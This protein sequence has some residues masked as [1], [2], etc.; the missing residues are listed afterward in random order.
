MQPAVLLA[1]GAG[2][3]L[4]S[5]GDKPKVDDAPPSDADGYDTAGYEG[6]GP[7]DGGMPF[8]PSPPPSGSSGAPPSG[9]G[10]ASGASPSGSGGA[11]GAPPSGSSSSSNPFRSAPEAG[12]ARAPRPNL[13]PPAAVRP[14]MAARPSA[15]APVGVASRQTREA[16][17]WE[18]VRV[19]ML[20][21]ANERAWWP[22]LR[23]LTA[24]ERADWRELLAMAERRELERLRGLGVVGQGALGAAGLA[25]HAPLAEPDLRR[26]IFS[27]VLNPQSTVGPI[28]V[29][30]FLRVAG[31]ASEPG[32]ELEAAARRARIRPSL[33]GSS[34]LAETEPSARALVDQ[35]WGQA[36]ALAGQAGVSLPALASLAPAHLEALLG[37]AAGGPITFKRAAAVLQ[38]IASAHLDPVGQI[39]LGAAL[40]ALG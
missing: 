12:P 5:R 27:A 39:A 3:F 29:A 34:A 24:R 13:A 35:F 37:L 20:A 6:P 40:A 22:A 16:E 26:L 28:A 36:R 15:A 7:A 32:R 1:L 30:F 9:S 23:D 11:S 31:E 2:L 17:L 21:P 38:Q 4:L 25:R 10:G 14:P 19:A 8:P 18:W 33:E